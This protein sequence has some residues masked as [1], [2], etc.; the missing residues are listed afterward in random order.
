MEKYLEVN[1]DLWNAK[2]PIHLNSEFYDVPAFKAGKSSLNPAELESLGDVKGK[3][4]LHL[5]CHF[6]M[7][8][9]SWSRLGAKVT[10]V[11]LS[12]R[13]IEAAKELNNELGLDAEFICSDVYDLK[14]VL[15]KKF[16]IVFTSYGTIGWLP[17]LDPWAEVVSHFL[18]PGGIFFIA[19][20][21]PVRWMYDDDCKNI[22]Y[23]YFNVEPII[24]EISASYADR[25]RIIKHLSYGWNH[26]LSEVFTSLMKQN[27]VITEF[28]EYPYSYYKLLNF[29]VKNE[30]GY[31]EIKG[32]EGK[33][34][35]MYSLKAAKKE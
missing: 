7:D 34:P 26:P 19:E 15:D 24:E 12:D 33:F 27:L 31:W 10:G 14:S 1:R 29:T 21:H 16:D 20:F 28:K 18:K 23:S 2:T 13:A 5:Q 17:E 25:D 6:G 8:S 4:I 3:S 35:L 30:L 32:L 9:L 11:D 22:D